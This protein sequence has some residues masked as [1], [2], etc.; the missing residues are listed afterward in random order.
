MLSQRNVYLLKKKNNVLA[1]TNGHQSTMFGFRNERHAHYIH[2]KIG[3][4]EFKIIRDTLGYILHFEN[5]RNY[6]IKGFYDITASTESYV[7]FIAKLNSV[8][9]L[10]VCDL[11]IEDK[12]IKLLSEEFGGQ[13]DVNT[14][15]IR[16]NLEKIFTTG[17]SPF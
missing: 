9:F 4:H 12:A 10:I 15:M 16:G 5:E 1:H 14:D 13:I 3:K 7:A 17:A 6:S 8:K 11:I 2:Q